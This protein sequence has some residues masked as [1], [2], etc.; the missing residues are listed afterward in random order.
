MAKS[1]KGKKS[2]GGKNPRRSSSPTSPATKAGYKNPPQHTRF[3]K[4]ASGN[5]GG[6]PKCSKNLRTI[7]CEMGDEKIPITTPEGRIFVTL[8][9][10]AAR[11]H[12][13]MMLKGNYQFFQGFHVLERGWEE[14]LK[15]QKYIDKEREIEVF[16]QII[17]D[18]VSPQ[19]LGEDFEQG[20]SEDDES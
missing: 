14:D 16:H 7:I 12:F 18:I 19:D 6:R 2:T 11:K 20:E 13:E 10:A 4:G 8:R 9:E 1:G 17:R 15:M 3:K 5:P